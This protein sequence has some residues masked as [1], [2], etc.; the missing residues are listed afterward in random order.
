M[1]YKANLTS[2]IMSNKVHKQTFL[3]V[4]MTKAVLRYLNFP[5]H[6]QL[7]FRPKENVTKSKLWLMLDEKF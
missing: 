6:S 4:E 5:A 3:S 2:G 7:S 1:W